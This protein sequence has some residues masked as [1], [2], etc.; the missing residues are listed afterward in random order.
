MTRRVEAK[1]DVDYF[2]GLPDDWFWDVEEDEVIWWPQAHDI[3]TT[4]VA[5][6]PFVD[7]FFAVQTRAASEVRSKDVHVTVTSYPVA[8]P[9]D[10]VYAAIG[11]AR[12]MS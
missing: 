4:Y 3:G 11:A 5:A 7:G 9:F 12:L 6:F 2:P 10:T 1:P 8:G